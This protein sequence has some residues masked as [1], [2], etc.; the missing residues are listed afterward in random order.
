[1]NGE[2]KPPSSYAEW[3]NCFEVLGT[4]MHDEE[5]LEAV[6]KGKVPWSDGIA[7]RFAERM[8]DAVSERL[9]KA[10]EQFGKELGRARGEEYAVVQAILALRRQIKYMLRFVSAPVFPE[11]IIKTFSAE[12]EKNATNIQDQILSEVKKDPSGR[13]VRVVQHTPL[14]V[15]EEPVSNDTSIPMGK[16]KRRIIF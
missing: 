7:Q 12:I 5:L 6:S 16:T 3:L 8:M 15:R 13:L 2:I 10:V 1:M 9:Q 4:G 11:E 14:L